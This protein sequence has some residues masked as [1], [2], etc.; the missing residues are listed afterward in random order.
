MKVLYL[1]GDT[2]NSEI[3]SFRVDKEVFEVLNEIK[4]EYDISYSDIMRNAILFY[5]NRLKTN[6]EVKQE[7]K[8]YINFIEQKHKSDIQR[9]KS[10]LVIKK[11]TLLY[12]QKRLLNKLQKQG[13]TNHQ[14]QEIRNAF[15]E[16]AKAL[17][18]LENTFKNKIKRRP[19]K[20]KKGVKA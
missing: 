11:Y 1:K 16:E 2:M 9:E 5:F 17:N 13:L 4:K 20:I 19:L 14:M 18:I 12:Q 10:K 15:K 8:D 6:K 3:L 7:L